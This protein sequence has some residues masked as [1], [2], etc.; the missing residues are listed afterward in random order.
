MDVQRIR[1]SFS[2]VASYGGD[3][4]AVHFYAIGFYANPSSG[5]CSRCRWR[6]SG[7]TSSARW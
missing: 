5:T 4:V 1:D 6:R 3:A 7:T 2:Q